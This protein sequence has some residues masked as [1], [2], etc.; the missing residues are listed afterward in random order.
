MTVAKL[1]ANRAKLSIYN[2]TSN[3]NGASNVQPL[4]LVVNT[5]LADDP[6]HNT[7]DSNYINNINN[8]GTVTYSPLAEGLASIGG[9]YNSPSSHVVANYCEKN[10]VLVVSP[11][12]SSEDQS[13]AAGSTPPSFSNYDN[14][15]TDVG[16]GK[17][18]KDNTTYTIPVNRNGSTY[19]DD[20]AYYLFTHDIVGY[21]AGFQN[22]RTYTV[23]FMGD[24]ANNLFLINTSNNGNGKKNLYDSS[25]KY[26]AK[27]HYA[28]SWRRRFWPR[29]WT[30]FLRPIPS[31]PRWFR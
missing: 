25:D 31:R 11:G 5:P 10:F 18:K 2:F 15:P 21:Q 12:I 23:G 16:E 24:L 30:S 22:V 26:Y 28:A 14:D 19:L 9:Y 13:P 27:Y 8:M 17:I 20:V 6:T 1:A 4:G 29:Y 7:L 3:S